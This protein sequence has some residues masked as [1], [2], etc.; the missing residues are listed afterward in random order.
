[1]TARD[2]GRAAIVSA[3]LE[4]LAE[5][6]AQRA[7]AGGERRRAGGLDDEDDRSVRR[8]NAPHGA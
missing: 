1:V 4:L 6:F 8:L 7:A 2:D 3:D 5:R